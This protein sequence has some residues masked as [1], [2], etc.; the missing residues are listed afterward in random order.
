V[1]EYFRPN[2]P[3]PPRHHRTW[4]DDI[5]IYWQGERL[6]R[7]ARYGRRRSS[8]AWRA[9]REVWRAWMRKADEQR[10]NPPPPPPSLKEQVLNGATLVGF[11]LLIPAAVIALPGIA[12]IAAV[13]HF[14]E[15]K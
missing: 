9:Y 5:Q 10:R 2:Y 8:S 6:I 12:V 7:K 4:G 3:L 15:K 14:T 1:T 11:A 13:V